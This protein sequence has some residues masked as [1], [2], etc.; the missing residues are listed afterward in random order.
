MDEP[1]QDGRNGLASVAGAKRVDPATGAA[2]RAAVPPARLAS[3]ISK[4]SCSSRAAGDF[5]GVA[6]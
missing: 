3:R 6:A 2:D 4:P 1:D 5:R